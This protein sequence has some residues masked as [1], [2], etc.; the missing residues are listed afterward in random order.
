MLTEHY[1]ILDNFAFGIDMSLITTSLDQ[2][3]KTAV[4]PVLLYAYYTVDLVARHHSRYPRF[5]YPVKDAWYPKA[6]KG[7]PGLPRNHR[8]HYKNA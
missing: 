3:D 4:I 8:I 6:P 5:S 7:A 2:I 1:F